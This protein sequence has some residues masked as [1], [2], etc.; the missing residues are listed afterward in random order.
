M[1]TTRTLG[2]LHFEDLD[3]KRF[4]DLARQLIY[5][6]KPWRKL[7]ATGRAGSD[8]GFD[9][10]GY[11]M[12][13]PQYPATP[14]GTMDDTD[15]PEESDEALTAGFSDR[16]W[17]V[18]CKRERAIGPRKLS[19]YMDDI[20]LADSE[21][22]HGVVLTAACDFSKKA[23]DIFAA[24]CRELGIEEWHLWGK[25]ELEDKLFQ[26]QNDHLLFAYFG[27]SISIRRRS[28]R[29]ELR[30]K[31]A[32][33][34]KATRLLQRYEHAYLLLR[35]PDASTYPYADGIR[36][37]GTD[38]P[39]W[40]VRKYKEINHL[41]LLFCTKRYFAYLDDDGK[42]WDAAMALN[43]VRASRFEDPWRLDDENE[44]SLRQHA[45]IYEAWN[46][47]PAANR[48][49]LEVLGVLPFEDIIDID[50]LGDEYFESPHIYAQYHNRDS[51]PFRGFYV[52]VE[53]TEGGDARILYVDDAELDRVEVFPK[54]VRGA[55]RLS[56]LGQS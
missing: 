19:G 2:P 8:D 28:L 37:P 33:K 9:A 27:I 54:E 24:K 44:D 17:L 35:P 20:V 26:P 41:G 14:G 38:E 16:L 6:F 12:L 1:T 49:W 47:L 4:E 32:M 18:Q 13:S 53:T 56:G 34:R 22:L 29:T 5:D 45:S 43:K 51:G 46:N 25:A 15:A 55:R 50:E 31:L 3:P 10:R 36:D 7:E 42:H 11:E 39:P 48:A 23:R 52:K 30:A 40:G 21:R